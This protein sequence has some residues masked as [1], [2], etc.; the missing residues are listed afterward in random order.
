[1]KGKFVE[2]SGPITNMKLSDID[3][4][5][6]SMLAAV[7]R[8]TA[9]EMKNYTRPFDSSERLTESITWRTM[10]DYDRIENSSDLI[11][12]PENK[13]A[14]DIGSK[15]P[16]AWFRENGTGP[17]MHPEGSEE[18]VKA[19]TAWAFSKGMSEEDANSVIAA[20]RKRGTAKHPFAYPMIPKLKYIAS[21]YFNVAFKNLYTRGSI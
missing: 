20:I 13:Y 2:T 5:V 14:V 1:M 17:H 19:V 11:D 7:G 21:K 9:E 16:H 15:A 18:F 6:N 3:I 8:A 12:E 10:A 4:N